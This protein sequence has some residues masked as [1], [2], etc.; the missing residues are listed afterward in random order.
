MTFFKQKLAVVLCL[1]IFFLSRSLI[2]QS[3]FVAVSPDSQTAKTRTSNSPEKIGT[4]TARY[5][6]STQLD[7]PPL[8]RV[9][10]R[11]PEISWLSPSVEITYIPPD[12]AAPMPSNPTN[13][14]TPSVSVSGSDGHWQA[15]VHSRYAGKWKLEFTVT[16]KVR[17]RET[18]SG[19][20]VRNE[21]GSIFE[22]KIEGSG[23]CTFKATDSGFEIV[24]I[25]DDNFDGRS[26]T[27]VGVGETGT[28]KVLPI[29]ET[30]L[31]DILPLQK[32]VSSNETVLKMAPLD[33]YFSD[34]T[35][36]IAGGVKGSTV[37]TAIDANGKTDTYPIEILQPTKIRME[38]QDKKATHPI[39]TL[40]RYKNANHGTAFYVQTFLV[41]Y[42][43]PKE[44]SFWKIKAYEGYAQYA[45]SG[46]DI[47]LYRDN[48]WGNEHPE[49]SPK[50][51]VSQGDITKGCHVLG[52][53]AP[54][55]ENL[56]HFDASGTLRPD[57][58]ASGWD[59]GY[60]PGSSAISLPWKY[61]VGNTV[62]VNIE[63][64]EATMRF[65]G[66]KA[67]I[68][69]DGVTEVFDYYPVVQ[70]AP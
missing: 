16:A 13:P 39:P 65:D 12:G 68:T 42:F 36:F 7:L 58:K 59:S 48:G 50:P 38:L 52:P 53:N 20:Y 22:L 34:S 69:K 40:V 4:N 23:N 1:F 43:E 9:E 66:T 27:S 33:S 57:T 6:I 19:D 18:E 21:D 47:G 28:I 61:D 41:T 55:P 51:G 45:R 31:D 15:K 30:P 25:P 17:F 46:D 37:V 32:F 26:L 70:V 14:G 63:K 8:A 54:N 62:G 3:I 10:L 29:G 67:H 56:L 2:A 64:V 44:V 35:T 11:A 5:D 60:G 24:L 49:W